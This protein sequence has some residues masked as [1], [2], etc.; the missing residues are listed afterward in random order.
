MSA[1]SELVLLVVTVEEAAFPDKIP[2]KYFSPF[3]DAVLFVEIWP[4]KYWSPLIIAAERYWSP[5]VIVDVAGLAA[6]IP[7]KYLSA[8]L[9]FVLLV[10]TIPLMYLSAFILFVLLVPI[11]PLKYLSPL[12]ILALRN[13]SQC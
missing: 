10:P 5:L 3:S 13:W 12:R 1:L 11:I 6:K 7:L 4:L 9:L 8:L 2:L